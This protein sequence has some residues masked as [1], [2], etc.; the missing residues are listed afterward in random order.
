M[1]KLRRAGGCSEAQPA[2]S[3]PGK[4]AGYASLHPPY[5]TKAWR[6][7]AWRPSRGGSLLRG[8]ERGEGAVAPD[9]CLVIALVDEPAAVDDHHAVEAARRVGPRQCRQ[10]AAAGEFV[11]Q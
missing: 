3:V 2:A 6:A 11:T 4:V 7:G 10:D 9:Q 5:G 8:E 1:V